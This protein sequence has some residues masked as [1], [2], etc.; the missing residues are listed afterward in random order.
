VTVG[1][2]VVEG[3]VIG[4]PFYSYKTRVGIT[5][6]PGQATETGFDLDLSDLGDQATGLIPSRVRL[7]DAQRRVI[8]ERDFVADVRGR[9]LSVYGVFALVVAFMTALVILGLL[10]TLSRRR[11]PENR[12]Q[13]AMQFLPAGIGVGFTSTFTLSATRV[14]SPSPSLWVPLVLACAAVAFVLGYLAPGPEG[15]DVDAARDDQAASA[16]SGLRRSGRRAAAAVSAGG[17]AALMATQ[18]GDQPDGATYEEQPA[19]SR[20]G[21]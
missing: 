1:A 16:S 13:R 18:D 11:L 2:V 15:P 6:P 21:P 8:A 3:R 12:W 9:A 19:D 4:L 17:V 10:A 7:L 5:L 20:R 14:L